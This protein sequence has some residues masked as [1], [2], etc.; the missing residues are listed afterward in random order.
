MKHLKILFWLSL[1]TLL[2]LGGYLIG[3]MTSEK[4]SR[5]IQVIYADLE[6]EGRFNIEKVITDVDDQSVVDHFMMIFMH[7]KETTNIKKLARKPDVYISIMSPKRFV[8]LVNSSVWFTSEGAII[9]HREEESSQNKTYYQ[10]DEADAAYIKEQ[11]EY[12]D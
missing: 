10:I 9:A 8:G 5:E 4:A 12:I 11:I 3:S 2:F 7:K 6:H 1:A